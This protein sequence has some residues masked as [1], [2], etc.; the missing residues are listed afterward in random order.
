MRFLVF[1]LWS[2]INLKVSWYLAKFCEPDSDANQ[3]NTRVL[4]PEAC[5][6]DRWGYGEQGPLSIFFDRGPLLTKVYF[7]LPTKVK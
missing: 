5:R 2:I 1:E 4:N 6:V 3:F 7:F